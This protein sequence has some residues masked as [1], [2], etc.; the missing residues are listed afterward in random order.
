M[1]RISRPV[2]RN[3]SAQNA[4]RRLLEPGP[5]DL[6]DTVWPIAWLGLR[7]VRTEEIEF[8]RGFKDLHTQVYEEVLA[9]RGSRISDAR[10][11]IQAVYDVNHMDVVNGGQKSHAKLQ[12]ANRTQVDFGR[13]F[14][15]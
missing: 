2:P 15:A 5:P 3:G 4:V 12:Q 10:P 1:M 6:R 13:R 14:A 8:S 11:A 7:S 9:G